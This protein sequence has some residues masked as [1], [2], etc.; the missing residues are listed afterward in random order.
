MTKKGVKRT[1]YRG[2]FIVQIHNYWSSIRENISII[3]FGDEEPEILEGSVTLQN[4]QK[5]WRESVTLQ[6]LRTLAGI[7]TLKNLQIFWREIIATKNL[8][9]NFCK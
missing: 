5:F 3:K 7:K 6:N 4:I 9:K 8:K 2:A 1:N